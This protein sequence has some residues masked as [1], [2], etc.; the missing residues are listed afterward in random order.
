M[1]NKMLKANIKKTRWALSVLVFGVIAGVAGLYYHHTA[2]PKVPY[3]DLAGKS[4]HLEIVSTASAQERG[5][6]GRSSL[7]QNEA[8]LFE[9][10]S[11][12]THCFWMK[13]MRF[14]I[15]MLWIDAEH[16]VVHIERA[17]APNTYPKAFCPD[18]PSTAVL[19]TNANISRDMRVGDRIAVHK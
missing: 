10:S 8:M 6:G 4:L 5:L 15:D 16:R 11:D 2:V 9:F 12:E 19:E 1:W 3:V 13:D 7:G 18:S 14:P 17:V